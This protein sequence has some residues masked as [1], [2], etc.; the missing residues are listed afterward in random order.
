M[1]A[2]SV[3]LPVLLNKFSIFKLSSFLIDCDWLNFLI[4]TSPHIASKRTSFPMFLVS[5]RCWNIIPIII[6]SSIYPL[7]QAAVLSLMFSNVFR[8]P[9]THGSVPFPA[10]SDQIS[11]PSSLQNFSLDTKSTKTFQQK[12]SSESPRRA[13]TELIESRASALIMDQFED[14]LE[15]LAASGLQ[16]ARWHWLDITFV[17]NWDNF[18]SFLF[19]RRSSTVGSVDSGGSDPGGR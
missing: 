8:V 1:N 5:R 10:W 13:K 11:L 18:P 12:H 17:V 4:T 7:P 14:D 15:R 6:P 9:I 2:S 3:K 19:R 16:S